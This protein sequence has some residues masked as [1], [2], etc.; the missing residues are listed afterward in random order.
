MKQ[1]PTIGEILPYQRSDSQSS[2]FEIEFEPDS[3][4]II[5]QLVEKYLTTFIYSML[6]ENAASEHSARMTAMDN[7][8][9]NARDMLHKLSHKYNR[10]RQALITKEL[11]E[12]ISGAQAL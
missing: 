12:I 3:S 5:D 6:L 8:T 11:I 9:R 4:L 10:T 1:E 7:A 2:N